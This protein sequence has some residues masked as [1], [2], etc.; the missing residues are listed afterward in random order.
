MA[1]DTNKG[2]WCKNPSPIRLFV[3]SFPAQR[4]VRK[5]EKD[6]YSKHQPDPQ[7]AGFTGRQ[8]QHLI[9]ILFDFLCNNSSLLM[10]E[11]H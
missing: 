10:T 6:T 4:R 5:R 2:M 7:H 3:R 9:Q 11:K 8:H 1:E